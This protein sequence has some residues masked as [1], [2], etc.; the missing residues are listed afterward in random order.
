M[1]FLGRP[2][3]VE[4][5]D[6]KIT[7]LFP[8]DLRLLQEM[9]NKKR[10]K[11]Q[12]SGSLKTVSKADLKALKVGEYLK[13]KTYRALCVCNRSISILGIIKKLQTIKNFSIVQKTPVRVLHRR[14]LFPR[15]RM[16]YECRARTPKSEE[17]EKYYSNTFSV[18]YHVFFVIDLKTQAG[19]YVKEFIH[20]DFGRTYPNLCSFL[21]VKI[22]ILALDVIDVALDWP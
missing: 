21:E 13:S 3:A 22:D 20:G 18:D 7:K 6:P 1:L 4:L 2:F 19:T 12:I 10:S 14:S 8:E 17:L 15:E 16:V 9:I 11:V 5:I